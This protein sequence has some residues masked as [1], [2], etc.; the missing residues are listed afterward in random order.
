MSDT[1]APAEK[2]PEQIRY[3]AW[4]RDQIENHGLVYVSPGTWRGDFLRRASP[5]QIYR[6]LNA[7]NDAIAAGRCRV[8]ENIDAGIKQT[9][10]DALFDTADREKTT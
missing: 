5:E 7:F 10:F 8:I 6:E 4:L 9:R 2:G 3:E 1:I